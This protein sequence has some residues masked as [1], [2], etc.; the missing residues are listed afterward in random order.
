M[1][2]EFQGGR[3][4][5]PRALSA[6]ASDD[7]WQ[8]LSLLII[9]GIQFGDLTPHLNG[10]YC[11]YKHDGLH[12]SVWIDTIDDRIARQIGHIIHQNLLTALG[13]SYPMELVACNAPKGKKRILAS[14]S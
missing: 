7:L 9:G 14:I 10:I 8:E 6:R 4:N 13:R 12:Y 2:S 11:A 3:W 5:I 1:N